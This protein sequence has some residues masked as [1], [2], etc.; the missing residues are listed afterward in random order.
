MERVLAAVP[1]DQ[2]V[3]YLDDMLV[4]ASSFEGAMANL[5]GGFQRHPG[6]RAAA[7]PKEVP[8]VL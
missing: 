6:G 4:H 5:A 7:Q 2:C 3:V 1:R 8:P